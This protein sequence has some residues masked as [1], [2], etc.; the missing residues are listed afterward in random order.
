ME[1][2]CEVSPGDLTMNSFKTYYNERIED[3]NYF[4]TLTTSI[5]T[6]KSQQRKLRSRD[7][8]DNWKR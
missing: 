6:T 8:N 5:F 7:V 1:R 4:K 2:N 3:N